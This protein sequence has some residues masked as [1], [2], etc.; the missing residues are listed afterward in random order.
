MLSTS[1][2]FF[3]SVYYYS[4]IVK[5]PELLPSSF[6]RGLRPEGHRRGPSSYGEI[7]SQQEAPV[8]RVVGLPFSGPVIGS[9]STFLVLQPLNTVPHIVVTPMKLFCCNFIIV[10]LPPL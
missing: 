1:E 10:I 7:G 4:T 3:L 6:V 2:K 8:L 5:N 9:Q